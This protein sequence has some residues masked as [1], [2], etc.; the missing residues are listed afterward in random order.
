M[1]R[2]IEKLALA[3]LVAINLTSACFAQTYPSRTMHL[4][5]P[6]APG[7][8][9]DA[10]AR[11][12]AEK[13]RISLGQAVIVDNKPGASGIIGTQAATQSPAVKRDSR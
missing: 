13:L 8:P 5:V 4:I 9:V 12:I 7:G 2:H 1:K 3:A 10:R 11:W 6:S